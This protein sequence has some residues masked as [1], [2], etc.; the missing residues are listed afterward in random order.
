MVDKKREHIALLKIRAGHYEAFSDIYDIYSKQIYRYV[1]FKVP[2]KEK[3]EDITSDVFL[4]CWE[5][6]N[7]HNTIKNFQAFIYQVARN[8]IADFYKKIKE[9]QLPEDLESVPS[10]SSLAHNIDN[11][12]DWQILDKGIRELGKINGKWQ[13][14]IV[15]KHIEGYSTK[16]ISKILDESSAN[17]RVLIHR[18]MEKLKEIIGE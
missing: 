1:Y 15:L 9:L 7:K 13:E 12:S 2:T 8:S 5:Y 18:A 14:V 3:A 16:E 10:N 4:K 11:M 17:V 6:I